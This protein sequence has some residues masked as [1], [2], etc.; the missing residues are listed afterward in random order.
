MARKAKALPACMRAA[1]ASDEKNV[2]CLPCKQT[3]KRESIYAHLK[4]ASHHK[5]VEVSEAAENEAREQSRAEDAEREQIEFV[6]LEA[7]RLAA[8][9]VDTEMGNMKTT[10]QKS[11][12]ERTLWETFEREGADFTMDDG[13]VEA[14]AK[15]RAELAEEIATFGI[16]NP[17]RSAGEL[18]FRIGPDGSPDEDLLGLG[19]IAEEDAFLADLL[20]NN[21]RLNTGP[22][23]AIQTDAQLGGTMDADI[24][25]SH[26]DSENYPYPNHPMFLMDTL[27]NLLRIPISDALM[28]MFLYVLR[29]SGVK[30]VLSFDGFRK[31]Q[32]EIRAKSGTATL[33]CKSPRGNIFWMLDVRALIAQDW[34]NPT[35]RPHIQLFPE[36]PDG[37]VSQV[38]HTGKW[39]VGLDRSAL[40]P[41]FDA[42]DKHYYL[43]ELSRLESGDLVIPSRWV[44][45]R[46]VLY[47]DAHR[48]SIT[49]EGFAVYDRT[50]TEMVRADSFAANFF[51]LEADNALP[52]WADPPPTMPNTLREVAEGEAMY[53]SLVNH[54]VDDVS[55]NRSKSWN[56][57]INTYITH[58]NLPRHLLQQEAHIHFVSTSQHAS[59]AEQFCDFKRVVMST[60]HN[61]IRIIDP[62]T[63]RPARIRIFVNAEPSD[64]PMQ[65]ELSGHIG[66]NGNHPCRKCKV[67]GTTISKAT[68]DGYH[69]LFLP[70]E[71][72][73]KE[74]VLE[75]L[76]EQVALACLGVEK[77]VRTRQ[78]ETGVKDPYTEHAIGELIKRAREEKKNNPE[79]THKEIQTDLLAWV[80]ANEEAI[81]NPFLTMPGLDPTKDTPVEILHTVLL[82]VVKYAWHWTHT[83][84]T[85]AQK[86][87][88]AQRLQATTTDG[89]SIHA[90]R[91][92]YIIQYANSLIG[93]QLKTVAQTTAFHTHDMLPPLQYKLWLAIGEMTSLIW[94]P[95]IQDMKIYKEDLTV[96]IANVLD[97]FAEIDPSKI[98]EKVKL[99]VLSHGVEDISRFGPLI[100]MC[101]EGFESFNGV[102]R[103][104][105]IHS[106]H[107]APS[108]DIAQQLADQEAH[109]H[110]LMGGLWKTPEG[111]IVRAGTRVRDF[112]EHHPTFRRLFGW[113]A[114]PP[115]LSG[116]FK[117]QAIPA[118]QTVRPTIRLRDTRAA[119]ALNAGDY[120]LDTVWTLCRNVVSHAQD[121]CTKSAWVCV[122]SPIDPS[123]DVMGRVE[124]ILAE[125]QSETAKAIA[126]IDVFEVAST[127]HTIFNMPWLTRRHDE[128]SYVIVAA[129]VR[130]VF[131]ANAIKFAFNVQHDCAFAGCTGTGLRNIRQERVESSV[132]ENFIQH[133]P[134]AH[135]YIINT[136]SLHNPHLIRAVL[137]RELVAPIAHFKNR[138]EEHDKLAKILRDTQNR[139]QAAAAARKTTKKTSDDAAHAANGSHVG[140]GENGVVPPRPGSTHD[141][142]HQ[143]DDG[144]AADGSRQRPA[145][146]KRRR[147]DT[148][149]DD[150]TSAG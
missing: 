146:R 85:P 89:M 75:A 148:T 103:N 54:F 3:L 65:S 9:P 10:A 105:S 27:D 47:A 116:S 109:K 122:R 114:T 21:A 6:Q 39:H 117:L 28:R 96:A 11:R 81:Y 1:S 145:P 99:H 124:D 7:G 135:R 34:M 119:Q 144:A 140:D 5:C 18:G 126:I 49:D 74:T 51:D 14:S 52:N 15:R 129:S 48:V 46:G 123:V 141:E 50:K 24:P 142:E 101:T 76:R 16:W 120:A 88:Y 61:P 137:P 130:H 127:R 68:D 73:S 26:P 95:E 82:G 33:P 128:A 12:E 35:V 102:F 25:S 90:I 125:S 66:G 60:H 110:R 94:F 72:R 41:M 115:P 63:N 64:N 30:G 70:G 31:M 4:S 84:W 37:P 23:D 111:D 43:D 77:T 87:T 93:R 149:S 57:H 19:A 91:A 56:K 42:G 79:R 32:A 53:S 40:S 69:A 62:L 67:G 8:M 97:I 131:F 106:N 20:S 113:P 133:R 71:S 100:G 55:G 45:Y 13:G 78:T 2:R 98:V 104:A 136:H 38:W 44:M 92:N 58:A 147:A 134:D 138:R 22:E 80:D 107:L 118:G 108:R 132:H 150:I 29:E 121:V 143:G 36:I 59:A 83:S 139:K 17:G 112:L 86:A